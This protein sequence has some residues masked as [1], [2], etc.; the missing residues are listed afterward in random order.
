MQSTSV[1]K[2]RVRYNFYPK[3]QLLCLSLLPA[4]LPMSL[5]LLLSFPVSM[6]LDEPLQSIW[7]HGSV[8]GARALEVGRPGLAV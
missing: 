2:L 1:G 4:L 7:Q 5:C 6:L 3:S 8:E